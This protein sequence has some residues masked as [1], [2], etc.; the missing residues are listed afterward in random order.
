MLPLSA[1]LSVL[2]VFASLAGLS[3]SVNT[4]AIWACE[5][6]V[7]M[8]MVSP[9]GCASSAFLPEVSGG[10]GARFRYLL[11]A[12]SEVATAGT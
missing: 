5:G 6:G 12:C 9:R 7:S 2:V 3:G 11:S 10:R 4:Q 1:L 8:L